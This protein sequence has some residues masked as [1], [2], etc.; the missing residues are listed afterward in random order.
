M[1][2][3]QL[4]IAWIETLPS[5]AAAQAVGE[6]IGYPEGGGWKDVHPAV[7]PTSGPSLNIPTDISEH[8]DII[9]PDDDADPEYRVLT[10]VAAE[11]ELT[12]NVFPSTPTGQ[13]VVGEGMIYGRLYLL[14]PTEITLL[15][16]ITPYGMEWTWA[17]PLYPKLGMRWKNWN[18]E[19]WYTYVWP[20]MFNVCS[21]RGGNPPNETSG[22]GRVQL[23]EARRQKGLPPV[24]ECWWMVAMQYCQLTFEEGH[25]LFQNHMMH[26][27][28]GG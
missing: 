23:Q 21:W 13:V 28:E 22:G 16:S 1:F 10:A 14:D 15:S 4:D 12:R 25:A 27:R 20:V 6:Y 11:W 17:Y 5:G 9:I 2:I 26:V 19:Y 3:D 7:P 18:N 24:H 8:G